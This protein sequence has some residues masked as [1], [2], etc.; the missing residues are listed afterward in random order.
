LHAVLNTDTRITTPQVAQMILAEFADRVV[1]YTLEP[2]DGTHL[3]AVHKPF[4]T[5]HAGGGSGHT[6]EN[7]HT[8]THAERRQFVQSREAALFKRSLCL[9]V[10]QGLSWQ[11][12]CG[13]AWSHLV[14]ASPVRT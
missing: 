1:Q 7:K 3:E 2:T 12:V 10:A 9:L 8:K 6:E 11:R 5:T 4:Q 14:P 13:L